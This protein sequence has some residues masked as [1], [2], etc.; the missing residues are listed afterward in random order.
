MP[1]K[2]RKMKR[3]RK[4]MM[5]QRNRRHRMNFMVLYGEVNQRKEVS[6]RLQGRSQRSAGHPHQCCSL[7]ALLPNHPGP[8]QPG[9][10]SPQPPAPSPCPFASATP[11][12]PSLCYSMS[13]AGTPLLF[14]T[15]SSPAHP[16]GPSYQPPCPGHLPCRSPLPDPGLVTD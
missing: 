2:S 12:P 14:L 8:P 3:M 16:Q 1:K 13:P 9:P 11:S 7:G 15:P 5:A 4:K 6:G 10:Q